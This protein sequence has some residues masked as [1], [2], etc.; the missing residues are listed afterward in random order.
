MDDDPYDPPPPGP[1]PPPPPPT[2]TGTLP[3]RVPS[4][5][6]LAET[7]YSLWGDLNTP[8]A[9]PLV[10]IHGGPGFAHDYLVPI[11]RVHATHG[12]P[13]VM[14]DQV[15]SGRST[16]FRGR[17]DEGFWTVELYLA[18]LENLVRGLG[19]GRYDVLGHSWGGVLGVMHAAGGA[20]E[21]RRGRGGGGVRRLVLCSVPADVEGWR[22]V[23]GGLRR[24]LPPHI[25]HPL[26]TLPP[27]SPAYQTASIAF[28]RLH[29]CRT[30][31]FPPELLASLAS[32]A[33]DSAAYDALLRRGG[34]LATW[35][36]QPHLPRLND[37]TVP[38]GMLLVNGAYDE[39]GADEGAMMPYFVGTGVRRTRWVVFGRSAQMAWLEE[40]ERFV[41]V[42]GGFLG[43]RGEKRRDHGEGG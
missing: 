25:S 26:L 7:Y 4:T 39:A 3:F 29:L 23:E 1:G 24:A 14:Y 5:G 38:G 10:C 20:G 21:G 9:V 27:S 22:G 36:A 8:D 19:I 40:G 16:R 35:S 2:R 15:G 37:A 28:Y 32:L 33:S 43:G 17:R 12:V 31:T 18:E 41:G 6:E 11:S 13:V 42:L 30:P 34:P